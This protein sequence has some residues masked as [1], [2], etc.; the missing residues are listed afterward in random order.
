[1]AEEVMRAD[2]G[3]AAH[4]RTTLCRQV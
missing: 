2:G 1:V 4:R 3:A